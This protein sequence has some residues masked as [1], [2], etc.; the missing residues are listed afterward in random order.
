M[1]G[2]FFLILIGFTLTVLAQQADS[3]KQGGV[4]PKKELANPSKDQKKDDSFGDY[5]QKVGLSIWGRVKERFNLE[6]VV[7]N[8]GEKKD[9]IL[10][11]KE[12]KAGTEKEKDSND[13]VN[14]EPAGDDDT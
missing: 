10:G 9:K 2:L 12:K 3:V 8:L 13:T 5:V 14:K 6:S 7:D 4:R 11:D 1:R